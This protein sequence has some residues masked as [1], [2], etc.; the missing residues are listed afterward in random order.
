MVTT[1]M[2][3]YVLSV[4]CVRNDNAVVQGSRAN[5]HAMG[6]WKE[7]LY[8]LAIGVLL[9]AVGGSYET[10]A[11]AQPASNPRCDALCLALLSNPS[12]W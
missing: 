10:A 4:S 2:F 5:F 11:G 8:F 1:G 9:G 12:D 3:F 6:G 7:Q